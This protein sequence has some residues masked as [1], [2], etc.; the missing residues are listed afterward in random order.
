[1]RGVVKRS[2][3]YWDLTSDRLARLLYP[4]TL[5]WVVGLT[6]VLVAISVVIRMP[7]TLRV[8]LAAT[9]YLQLL[10]HKWMTKTARWLTFLGNGS[11]IIPLGIA[12]LVMAALAKKGTEG[13]Y[14]FASLVSL[15]LNVFLKNI[16][17][18]KRPGE[19]QVRVHPGPRWGF[20]YPSGHSMGTAAFYGFLAFLVYLHLAATP[21]RVPL[22]V[23]LALLPIGTGLSRIYLGAHWLS[24]VVAGWAGG[25]LVL[26]TL[27][28][29]Y[30]PPGL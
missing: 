23:F 17:D 30:T 11:T 1:M 29:F 3:K 12:V 22:A 20:S 25:L 5:P 2:V 14:L 7:F 6:V 16:F 15:P 8:D 24:D 13:I 26:V 9:K 10:N 19:D 21:W 27:A 28:A 18:R 4:Q